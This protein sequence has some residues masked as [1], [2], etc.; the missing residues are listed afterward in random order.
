MF[1]FIESM[2]K[3][4]FIKILFYSQLISIHAIK[5]EMYNLKFNLYPI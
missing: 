4:V 1:K 2:L 3:Q 5:N